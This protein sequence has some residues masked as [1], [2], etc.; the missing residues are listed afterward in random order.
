MLEKAN[1]KKGKVLRK[2]E[3]LAADEVKVDEQI[4]ASENRNA[5]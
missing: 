1:T 3:S 4:S 2:E 5:P